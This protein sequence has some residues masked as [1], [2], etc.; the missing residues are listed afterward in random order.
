MVTLAEASLLSCS[1]SPVPLTDRC[2]CF[3]AACEQWTSEA[4]KQY[5][6]GVIYPASSVAE[7]KA[8]CV[9]NSQCT[10]LGWAALSFPGL[11]CWLHGPWSGTQRFNPFVTFYTVK[12][13]YCQG[14]L[15]YFDLTLCTDVRL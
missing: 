3:C 7:C 2:S 1:A 4:N 15:Q 12:R 14:K 5:D 13:N 10:G 9:S 8:A 6:N 11:K